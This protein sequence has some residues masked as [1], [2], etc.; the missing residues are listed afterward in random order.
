MIRKKLKKA[1]HNKTINNFLEKYNVSAEYTLINRKMIARGIFLGLFIALIPIPFQMII[2]LLFT[3]FWKFNVPIAIIMC[4]VTN[5]FTMPFIYYIEYLTG[6]F[7]LGIEV[8]N[9]EI[10]ISWFNDNFDDILIPLY[11]GAFFYSISLSSLAYYIVSYD[12]KR[13][14]YK[15]R[16]AK[17]KID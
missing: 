16:N 10:T 5:P 9:V 3:F 7:L 14:V 12:W 11:F 1:N 4:W 2:V 15:E 13:S 17:K 6:S 8:L